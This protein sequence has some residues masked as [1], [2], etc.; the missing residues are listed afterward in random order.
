MIQKNPKNNGEISWFLIEAYLKQE[1]NSAWV[2]YRKIS[3][4][5]ETKDVVDTDGSGCDQWVP[6][7]CF[8]SRVTTVPRFSVR[9]VSSEG[10]WNADSGEKRQK[11]GSAECS[12][13][14]N[15]W[16]AA[17]GSI[18]VTLIILKSNVNLPTL[19]FPVS[20]VIYCWQLLLKLGLKQR[21]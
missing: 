17:S 5:Q 19:F 2:A 14:C 20:I 3:L 8:L 12:E 1:W 11:C 16:W 18:L 21:E 10:V 6:G 9:C 7:T 15:M 4:T 13:R